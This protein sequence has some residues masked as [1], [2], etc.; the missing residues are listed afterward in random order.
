MSDTHNSKQ[1]RF[2]LADG[3]SLCS[4]SSIAQKGIAKR[5]REE[6]LHISQRPRVECNRGAKKYT[7][8][9]VTVT[10]LQL[11][12]TT[13]SQIS[14]SAS[15]SCSPSKRPTLEHMMLLEDILYRNHNTTYKLIVNKIPL[16]YQDNYFP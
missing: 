16:S 8:G 3:C 12:P 5:C 10:S 11:G 13:Y 2:I 4:F 1:E 14:L 9:Y 7:C 15:M 6:K